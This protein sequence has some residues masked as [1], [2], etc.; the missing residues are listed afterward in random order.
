MNQALTPRSGMTGSSET[1]PSSKT[2]ID[3]HVHV[4]ALPDGTNGCYVS[5][6]LLKSPLFRLWVWKHGLDVNNPHNA[7]QKYVDDLRNEL[8]QSRHVDKAV[9]LGMDG[10]YDGSGKPDQ[11]ATEFLVGNDYI[12][13]LA[14]Q[15]PET[16]LAGVSINPQ[17]RDAVEELHRC[18]DNGAALV[19]VLPNTQ[20]F[21][22]ANVRYKS[23]YRAMAQR[24][25]PLLSH[26]GYEFSLIGKDQ[27]AGDPNRLRVPLQ[28]VVTVISAHACSFGLMLY[29]NFYPSLLELI[30]TYPNF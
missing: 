15:F 14:H 6:G 18:V 12:L 30:E 23:F 20:R 9:L 1:A 17:R 22:P 29:E 24:N 27:A 4:A 13:H 5:A 26:V 10:V 11:S 19:K 8:R 28:Q 2:M 16:F 3:C 7:N 25:I 21:D